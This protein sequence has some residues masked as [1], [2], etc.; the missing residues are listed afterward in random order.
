MAKELFFVESM[1]TPIEGKY[2]VVCLQSLK[3]MNLSHVRLFEQEQLRM[4]NHKGTI[5]EGWYVYFDTETQGL[6]GY[7]NLSPFARDRFREYY[8]LRDELAERYIDA[9][10]EITMLPRCLADR[11][12]NVVSYHVNVGHGN[13]SIVL[14]EYGGCC[15]IWMVDCSLFDKT[16]HWYNYQSNLN[17]VFKLFRNV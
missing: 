11:N 15:Q 2:S 5:K 6:F 12:T 16:N 7:G 13:C 8:K 3:N 17:E 10:G 1:Y 4:H 14:V 9:E